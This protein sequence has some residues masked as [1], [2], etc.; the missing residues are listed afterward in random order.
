[1]LILRVF[2]WDLHA[3]V[4]PHTQMSCWPK[5][6]AVW[7]LETSPVRWKTSRVCVHYCKHVYCFPT[8]VSPL[9]SSPFDASPC[10]FH[11]GSSC[12]ICAISPSPNRADQF[13][14]LAKELAEPYYLYGKALLECARMESTVLGS[15]IPGRV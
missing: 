3:T 1:M 4:D 2:E 11:H 9:P 13:G 7:R 8:H 12:L 6:S 15:G 5:V 10:P 14:Q